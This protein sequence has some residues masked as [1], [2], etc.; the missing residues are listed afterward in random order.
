MTRR[1]SFFAGL[2]EQ[3]T[4]AA[5]V[6]GRLLAFLSTIGAGLALGMAARLMGAGKLQAMLAAILFWAAPF[7]IVRFSAINDPQ[8]LGNF[9]D[10]IGLV[11]IHCRPRNMGF[12]AL[13]ALFLSAASSSSWP[14]RARARKRAVLSSQPASRWAAARSS[15]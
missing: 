15:R 14:S 10:A 3:F 8:M 1:C 12:I 7:V 2:I 9:L 5:I 13:S 11:L 4:T 6:A